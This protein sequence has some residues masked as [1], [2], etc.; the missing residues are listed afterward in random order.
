MLLT[1]FNNISLFAV[2][3]SFFLIVL[4]K[5]LFSDSVKDLERLKLENIEK[6]CLN[7]LEWYDRHPGYKGEFRRVLEYCKNYAKDVSPE[8]FIVNPILSDFGVM[9]G[10]NTRP[11]DHIHQGIDIIG[12]KNEPIIAVAD[13]R[14]L[15]TTIEDCWGSTV[16]I[17]HGES[18]EGKKLIVVYAHVGKFNVKENDYVKRG[19]VIAKLPEKVEFMCMARVRHLHLQIGQK[20]CHKEEKDNWGCK[21][22]IKDFYNSLN[23]HTLWADGANKVSCFNE[24]RK[25]I[26]GTLTYPFKCKKINKNLSN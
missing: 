10:V 5:T 22:F 13:G 2:T 25:Y 11:R 8:G 23:P 9:S 24:N 17:D 7:S 20:Y 4:S 16:I 6:L 1:K 26:N 14:V 21:Y 15:E 18:L 3:V 19:Q 12:S